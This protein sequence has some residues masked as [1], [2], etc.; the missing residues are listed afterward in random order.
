[1]SSEIIYDVCPKCGAYLAIMDGIFTITCSE[2]SI[3]LAYTPET[4]NLIIM[5]D[6]VDI[7][8]GEVITTSEE[9]KKKKKK[10]GK[11]RLYILYFFLGISTLGFG[12]IFYMFRNLKDLEAHHL[13]YELEKG[14]APLLT[15]GEAFP[16][17]NSIF[18]NR[19][20][21][22]P[23]YA[24]LYLIF[25]VIFDLFTAINEKYS[26]LYYHL[27]D[28]E[29][30]TA[31]LKSPHVGWLLFGLIT[32]ILSIPFFSA[33]L[34]LNIIFDFANY[35]YNYLFYISSSLLA[36]GFLLL[37]ICGVI[38]QKAFNAHIKAVDK[39]KN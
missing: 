6:E 25:T 21:M 27:K 7:F 4:S 14:A 8:S 30:E 29:K 34:S 23:W 11:K 16:S 35:P 32:F 10:F 22:S 36:F 13:D 12:F 19:L 1:M 31:P 37:I 26:V 9:S 2:C 3:K 33:M 39:M 38:W 17:L 20:F 15:Y 28:Q 5:G 18:Q 24:G